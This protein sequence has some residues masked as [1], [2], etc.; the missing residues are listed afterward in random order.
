MTGKDSQEAFAV[1]HARYDGR[2]QQVVVVLV[3]RHCKILGILKIGPGKI[4]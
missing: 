1:I 3:R 2:L 4:D